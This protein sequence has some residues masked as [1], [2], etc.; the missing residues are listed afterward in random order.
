MCQLTGKSDKPAGL[1]AWGRT[2]L[3]VSNGKKQAE[4]IQAEQ[5]GGEGQSVRARCRLPARF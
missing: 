5:T 3:V 2:E 4:M 1:K